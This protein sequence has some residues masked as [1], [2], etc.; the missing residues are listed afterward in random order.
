MR[1]G[2]LNYFRHFLF[3][4]RRLHVAHLHLRQDLGK[5]ILANPPLDTVRL[6]LIFPETHKSRFAET[7]LGICLPTAFNNLAGFVSKDDID[8]IIHPFES[9]SLFEQ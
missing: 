6:L 8:K 7:L 9:G 2:G 5:I 4:V 1:G 3:Q